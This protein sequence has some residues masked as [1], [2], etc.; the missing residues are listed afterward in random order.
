MVNPTRQGGAVRIGIVGAGASGVLVA[1]HLLRRA[2][3]LE[4]G[5]T[6]DPQSGQ[7][8]VLLIDP[9]APGR[10]VAYGTRDPRHLL[11]VRAAGMSALADEPDH[12]QA[13]AG[14]GADD[15][16]PRMRYAVYLHEL[17]AR[18]SEESSARL[19][20]IAARA[21][22]LQRTPSGPVLHLDSGQDLAVDVVVLA[23]GNAAPRCPDAIE[24]TD[25]A[26]ARA[27][28][29]PW[30]LPPAAAGTRTL[31]LGSG[32]TAV[33]IAVTRLS[34]RDDTSV[35]L[36]SR[37]G[38]LPQPHDDPWLPTGQ[39]PLVT[40]DDVREG[41]ALHDV[42]HRL[43]T[44][45]S[46]DTAGW[47]Q[48]IDALRPAT[49]QLWQALDA[50][51]KRQFLRHAERFWEVH[52]HRMPASIARKVQ[53]WRTSGRL[54][55]EAMNVSAVDVQRVDGAP[56]IEEVVMRDRDGRELNGDEWVVATG[57]ASPVVGNALLSLLVGKGVLA[58]DVWGMGLAMDPQTG[59]ACDASGRPH[60]DVFV[61][62]PLT[63]G[64]LWECTA[65]PD[66]RA[67]AERV[68]NALLSGG[69]A[70]GQQHLR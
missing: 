42:V 45:L 17:L 69:P 11:N 60:S 49:Q 53:G 44:G 5:T 51:Q 7:V 15:Y 6:S 30:K 58:A 1:I 43:R 12:F 14:A 54:K 56:A 25:G 9:E 61:V 68:A 67:D 2:A 27:R 24:V 38:L 48:R 20:P 55:V 28:T 18:S 64:T 31:V 29:H 47:R 65:V 8:E 34:E 35:T 22:D 26:R 52:R 3:D 70:G 66:I 50:D 57:P 46:G 10:G 36:V 16:L 13:W 23:T 39:E 4:S 37:H 19:I 63:K 40:P 41:M 32:L 33:D 59:R 62:G 21:V